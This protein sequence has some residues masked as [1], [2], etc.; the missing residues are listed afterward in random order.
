MTLPR[1]DIVQV[2]AAL[3][4]PDDDR[5]LAARLKAVTDASLMLSAANHASIRMCSEEAGDLHALARSGVGSERPPPPFRRGEGILGWVAEH[6]QV[7]RVGETSTDPR[8]RSDGG[9]GFEVRS[10]MSVP[11]FGNG[12]V[13]GVLSLSAEA[14]EAFSEADERLGTFLAT[15][16]AMHL[17]TASLE[18]IAITDHG[19]LAFNRHYLAPRLR[20]EIARA[21]RTGAPL[22]LLLLDLDRFKQV[23]DRFGHVAGDRVLRAFADRVREHV[24]TIDVLVR[25]G[26]EE[27]VLLMPA[28]STAD[29]YAVAERIREALSRAPLCDVEAAAGFEPHLQTVSIGVA[30]W[31]RGEPEGRFE[32]RADSAM[33]EAKRAGRN[34][35]VIA[36]PA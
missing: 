14:S 8:F 9:R 22:S 15:F 36:S 6:G 24:R 28:T 31:S 13:V 18:K 25:R 4:E 12:R 5:P 7:A 21:E 16:A 2:L 29:A 26:G 17:K 19:T 33:Y 32:S 1:T 27:F 34:R 23:N 35:V 20:E 3:A 11:I 10:V 30:T